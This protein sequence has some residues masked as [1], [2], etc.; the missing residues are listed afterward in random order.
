V[1]Q[2]VG[3]NRAA[4]GR[5][6]NEED[7]EAAADDRNLVAAE[8]APDLLPVAAGANRFDLAELTVRFD[9]S[10]AWEPT[11]SRSFCSVATGSRNIVD[12]GFAPL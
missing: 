3:R 8:A 10:P 2:E 5:D 1:T 4:R 6:E 7:D 11:S 12:A 9:P